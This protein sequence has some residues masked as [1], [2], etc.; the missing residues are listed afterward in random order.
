MQKALG[1]MLCETHGT[2]ADDRFNQIVFEYFDGNVKR[3]RAG[4]ARC[5]IDLQMKMMIDAGC[6]FIEK[7][8]KDLKLFQFQPITSKEGG[9]F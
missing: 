1:N 2:E 8:E 4:C 3:I 9:L 6:K 5:Y 7:S